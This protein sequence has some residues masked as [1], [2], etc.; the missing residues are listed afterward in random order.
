MA[1]NRS[2]KAKRASVQQAAELRSAELRKQAAT[3]PDDESSGDVTGRTEQ[4]HAVEQA[5]ARQ[6]VRLGRS[7]G[8]VG[9]IGRTVLLIATFTLVGLIVIWLLLAL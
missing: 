8:A 3:L 2:T 7:P 5:M 4:R 1:S 9:P 6:N